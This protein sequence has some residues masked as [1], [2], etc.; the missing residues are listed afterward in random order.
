MAGRCRLKRFRIAGRCPHMGRLLV[1]GAISFS[2]RNL[3]RCPRAKVWIRPGGLC[4]VRSEPRPAKWDRNRRQRHQCPLLGRA[5]RSTP[6]AAQRGAG[7]AGVDGG[8]FGRGRLSEAVR[9]IVT[10]HWPTDRAPTF[11][12][13]RHP[14]SSPSLSWQIPTRTTSHAVGAQGSRTMIPLTAGRAQEGET[15]LGRRP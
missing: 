3:R 12:P 5:A 8:A 13:Q 1:K 6:A 2:S 7:G 4:P 10:W 11:A 9:H 14:G 15:I